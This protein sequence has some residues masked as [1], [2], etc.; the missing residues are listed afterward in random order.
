MILYHDQVEF[1]PGMQEW[2][3]IHKVNVTYHISTMKD[4]SH[5]IIA[6]DG[7][8]AFDKIQH[9][10]MTKNPEQMEYRRN[11]PQHNEGHKW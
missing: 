2:F 11:V 9:P 7:E 1:I 6:V 4:K 10:F 5:I 8:K 3:S